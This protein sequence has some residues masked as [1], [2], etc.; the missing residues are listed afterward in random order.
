MRGDL[1]RLTYTYAVS[2]INQS[3]EP[4]VDENGWKNDDC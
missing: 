1:A 3:D 4:W 2:Q